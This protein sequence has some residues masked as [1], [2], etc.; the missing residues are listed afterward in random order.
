MEK[1]KIESTQNT[2]QNA[3]LRPILQWEAPEYKRHEKGKLWFMIAGT[4]LL[5]LVAY[6]ILIDSAPAAIAFLLVAGL[7]YLVHH[8]EV[9]NMNV[10][11]TDIGIHVGNKHYLFANIESFWILY[12]PPHTSNLN[13][14]LSGKIERH[15][16]IELAHQDPAQ[17]R[18]FLRQQIPEV[19]G[20]GETFWELIVRL[21][22][23]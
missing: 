16:Q 19:E 12:E 9:K 7:Y 18:N 10:R 23:I 3:P 2:P 21:L 4:I 11:V 17:L 1:Q 6:F 15:I 8:S 5:L 13:L 14:K 20:K 22:K